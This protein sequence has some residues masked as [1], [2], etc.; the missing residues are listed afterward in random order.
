MENLKTVLAPLDFHFI[1]QSRTLIVSYR[2]N[3][4]SLR[5]TEDGKVRIDAN[6]VLDGNATACQCNIKIE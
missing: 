3:Y 2:E 1:A 5:L 4:I 6:L